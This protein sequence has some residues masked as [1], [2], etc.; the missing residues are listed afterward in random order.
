MST[1]YWI[2]VL[3]NLNYLF[4]AMIIAT[5]TLTGMYTILIDTPR[6][7]AYYIAV[8]IALLSVLGLV[9]TPSKQDL[10]VIYGVGGTLDYLNDNK[11]AKQVPDKCLQVLNEYLDQKL[12]NDDKDNR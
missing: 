3:G 2:N 9:F 1:L 12:T 10:Y 11:D 7:R 5:I 4:I 8:T 6:L